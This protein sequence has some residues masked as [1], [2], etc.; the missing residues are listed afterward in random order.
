MSSCTSH[1]V[2]FPLGLRSRQRGIACRRVIEFTSFLPSNRTG[3][4]TGLDQPWRLSSAATRTSS[5]YYVLWSNGESLCSDCSDGL[6]ARFPSIMRT[7]ALGLRRIFYLSCALRPSRLKYA[8]NEI[9]IG[10]VYI[11]RNPINTYHAGHQFAILVCP[12]PKQKRGAPG[13]LFWTLG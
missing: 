4:E 9:R 2:W 10:S 12:C 7:A 13:E 6:A 3:I 1:E 11:Y 8:I 5:Q